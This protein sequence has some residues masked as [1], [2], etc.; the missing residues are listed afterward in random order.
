[1]SFFIS[2][3]QLYLYQPLVNFLIYLYNTIA[4]QN[5][6]FAVVY[7]TVSL[8]V[9][10]LPF[11]ILSERNKVVYKKM[12]EQ[13]EEAQRVHRADPVYV[14]EY[15][16]SLMKKHK[17]RP[18][19]KTG[20]LAI[21]LL[22]LVL[23]YQVFI[24]GVQGLQLSRILYK[25]IDYP[26]RINTVFLTV[27]PLFDSG[28]FVFDVAQ[29]NAVAAGIV[30]FILFTDIF[31]GLKHAKRKLDGADLTYL[32]LFPLVSGLILWWLPMVKSLFIL[33]S[34]LFTYVISLLGMVF[35]SK[36]QDT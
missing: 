29:R 12:E 24:T 9:A 35:W 17:M 16:R 26:G 31:V 21:Q 6:G 32:F 18:W 30:A 1:M 2:F 8:R 27:P 34:I 13:I 33:T 11:S 23:L 19:A 3:W 36:K 4:D 22:V 15:I 10:L 5:L 7:L 25:S 20:E 14:K 28:D